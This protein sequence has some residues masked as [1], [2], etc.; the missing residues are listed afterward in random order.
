MTV[1][2]VVD[3][4]LVGYD[5][6]QIKLME[7][8][9][10]LVDENDV[11]IGSDSKKNCHLIT[12]TQEGKLHRAFS[13]FLFDSQNRLLLQQRSEEKITF[14]DYFTNTCCSHPLDL[15]N[16]K[17]EKDQLGVRLAAQRKLN[18]ELGIPK[19][20]INIAD[21]KYLTRIHYKANSDEKWVEHEVD[22]ILILKGDYELHVNENEVKSVRYV[23][24]D[25][26]N[27]MFNEASTPGS[28]LL[29]TP[30]FKLVCQNFLS[31]WWKKIDNL[32]E[33][34]EDSTIYHMV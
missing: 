8:R 13:V 27:A 12:P 33:V 26:L 28:N 7:E 18:H 30:W 6:E 4:G 9:C 2:N 29:L 1:S 34:E 25:E 31:K 11:A 17:I 5:E 16:E 15:P 21:F 19:E 22:Y 10:I 3:S 32:N 20:S 24:E 23:T 14:P